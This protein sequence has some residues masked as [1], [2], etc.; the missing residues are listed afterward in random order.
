MIYHPFY[1]HHILLKKISGL[2]YVVSYLGNVVGSGRGMGG[3]VT[4]SPLP[5]ELYPEQPRRCPVGGTVPWG[6]APPARA[7]ERARLGLVPPDPERL[8][9]SSRA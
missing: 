7:G 8:S 3:R 6:P 4:R 9:L 2:F 5:A 1:L